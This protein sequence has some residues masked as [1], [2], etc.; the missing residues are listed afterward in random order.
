MSDEKK[1][2]INDEALKII[3]EKVKD[4]NDTIRILRQHARQRRAE[5]DKREI[6]ILQLREHVR[7]LVHRS[8][9]GGDGSGV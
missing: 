6:E 7:S 1:V 2:V 9:S 3:A 4:L 5:L 8:K